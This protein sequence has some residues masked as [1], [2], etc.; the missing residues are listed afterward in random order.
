[1]SIDMGRIICT[2]AVGG[3]PAG[4][5][6]SLITFTGGVPESSRPT[7]GAG[8]CP[9][10]RLDRRHFKRRAVAGGVEN[11]TLHEPTLRAEYND[12]GYEQ[13]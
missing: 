6:R 12:G 4:N 13:Q 1:M 10:P 8:R 5:W 9:L 3:G 11:L 2:R 7:H